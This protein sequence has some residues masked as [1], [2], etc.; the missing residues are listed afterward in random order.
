MDILSVIFGFI[1]GLI[2]GMHI[3]FERWLTYLHERQKRE[4]VVTSD[5]A[6][7]SVITRSSLDEYAVV[8]VA[9]KDL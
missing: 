1:V 7:V 5:K 8:A 9:R 4:I 2:A 3:G 6:L